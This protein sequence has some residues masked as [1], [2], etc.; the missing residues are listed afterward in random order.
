MMLL[1]LQILVIIRHE[2]CY[3][4]ILV[5]NNFNIHVYNNYI[6]YIYIHTYIYIYN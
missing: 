4:I 2:N 1:L 3:G 6:L 5:Y